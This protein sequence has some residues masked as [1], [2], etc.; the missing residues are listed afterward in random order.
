M[1]DQLSYTFENIRNVPRE[2]I[3][4]QINHHLAEASSSKAE[5]RR[6]LDV[7]LAQLLIQELTM[8]EQRHQSKIMINC[9]VIITVLT[10]VIAILTGVVT[11]AT[12]AK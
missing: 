2:E 9:T 5:W 3:Q 8:R 7:L 10:G 12:V 11:W 1:S 4:N 6:S